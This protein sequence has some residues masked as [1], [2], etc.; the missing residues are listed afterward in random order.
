MEII[1][2]LATILI[3]ALL[4]LL[5][6]NKQSEYSF[7][8]IIICTGLVLN[9]VV[10]RIIVPISLIEQKI[11]SYGIDNS[12]FKVALKSLGIGYITSFISDSCK[13]SGQTA[14]AH[15]AELAGKCAI[16]IISFPLTLSIL[17]AAVGF[18]K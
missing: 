8:I 18:V 14:L 1:K 13:D 3:A 15:K 5:L 16:F 2:I 17:E 9:F 11:E 7:L 4:S 10:K 6:K 12:Y